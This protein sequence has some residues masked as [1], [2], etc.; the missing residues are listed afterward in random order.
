MEI[1]NGEY[2]FDSKDPI[3]GHG[4]KMYNARFLSK[5]QV[6]ELIIDGCKLFKKNSK[7]AS[8]SPVLPP[9]EK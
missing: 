1:L 8:E 4:G 6:G 7:K 5:E 2:N 3:F 9:T